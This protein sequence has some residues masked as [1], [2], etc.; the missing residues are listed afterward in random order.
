MNT[1]IP[2]LFLSCFQHC[3]T[4]NQ[5]RLSKINAYR[6]SQFNVRKKGR[7]CFQPLDKNA[8]IILHNAECFFN[9]C[10][11]HPIGLICKGFIKIR[12][13]WIRKSMIGIETFDG[14]FFI[15]CF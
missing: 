5:K 13:T 9:K 7:N 1:L 4:Q 15:G 10:Q 6:A 11:T 14:I 12:I 8:A 2:K 3:N